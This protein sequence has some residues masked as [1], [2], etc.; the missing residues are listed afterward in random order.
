MLKNERQDAKRETGDENAGEK[1]GKRKKEQ[2][3]LQT[4][5]V[6]NALVKKKVKNDG[7]TGVH[8][9]K[10]RVEPSSRQLMQYAHPY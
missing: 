2:K 10:W 1:K 4:R 3:G 6:I 7:S 5:Y 9:E 8:I